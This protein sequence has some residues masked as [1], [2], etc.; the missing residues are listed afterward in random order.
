M[1]GNTMAAKCFLAVCLLLMTKLLYGLPSTIRYA[2]PVWKNFANEDG[3]GAYVEMLNRIFRPQGIEVKVVTAPLN[4]AI[5]MVK[6]GDADL[7]GGIEPNDFASNLI[8]SKRPIYSGS[9]SALF[10]RERLKDWTGIETIRLNARS[11]GGPRQIQ[12][13][14]GGNIPI[15]ELNYRDQCIRM[16]L[17]DRLHYYVELDFVL[18]N[19]FAHAVENRPGSAFD[20]ES[21]TLK[22]KDSKIN[23]D[24]YVIRP[25]RQTDLY[26][27]FT[28]STAGREF[29]KIFADGFLRITKS[30]ELKQI[31][32]KW[33]VLAILPQQS[34]QTGPTDSRND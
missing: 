24:E 6:A 27:A 18:K 32:K 8:I 15:M 30:G 22:P 7:V 25:I 31:Y 12:M 4:R 5:A 9:V 14:V 23:P 10:R 33:D 26:M 21:K 29:E 1:K 13:M 3:T 17:A 11:A 34:A 2:V 19:V 16:L 20:I 28:K